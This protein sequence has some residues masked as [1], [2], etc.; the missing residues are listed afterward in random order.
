MLII[1]PKHG[2]RRYQFG[3]GSIIDNL[4]EVLTSPFAQKLALAVAS[5]AAKGLVQ[6]K[7]K[8]NIEEDFPPKKIHFDKEINVK[9]KGL[10]QRKRKNNIEEDFPPKKIRKVISGKGIVFD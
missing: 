3:G 8:N 9:G 1:K 4:K 2:K 6:R 10:V 5:G 7:R